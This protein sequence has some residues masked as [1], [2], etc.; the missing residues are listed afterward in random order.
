M[1]DDD[2]TTAILALSL[3]KSSSSLS[4]EVVAVKENDFYGTVFSFIYE[5]NKLNVTLGGGLNQYDGRH[6]GEL[7]WAFAAVVVYFN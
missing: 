7:V 5:K 1:Y 3:S 6:F 2:D 4:V